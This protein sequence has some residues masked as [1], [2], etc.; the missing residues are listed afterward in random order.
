MIYLNIQE[1]IASR[2]VQWGRRVTLTGISDATGR[3]YHNDA[4]YALGYRPQDRSEPFEAEVL[5][6]DPI[7]ATGSEQAHAPS[8][9][10]KGGAFSDNEFAGSS[11]RLLPRLSDRKIFS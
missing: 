9:M 10:T 6:H 8:E 2:Q 3:D 5:A 7:P 11:A 4:A 1:L